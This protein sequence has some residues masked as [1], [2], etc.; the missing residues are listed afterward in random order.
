MIFKINTTI[1][2]VTSKKSEIPHL[3]RILVVYQTTTIVSGKLPNQEANT[4]HTKTEIGEKQ[5]NKNFYQRIFT[6]L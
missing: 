3:N 5:E 2:K 4:A 6:C 1:T